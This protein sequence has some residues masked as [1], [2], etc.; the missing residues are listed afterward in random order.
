MAAHW[1]SRPWADQDPDSANHNKPVPGANDGASGVAVLLEIARVLKQN[2]PPVGV[3]IVLFDGED[4]GSEGYPDTYAAG[5]QY[6]AQKKSVHYAP[7]LGILLDMIG[8]REL[9][10]YREA[11]SVRYAPA[12][13]DLVWN[14]AARL[15]IS[16]FYNPVRHEVFDDHVPLLNVGIP[17]IDLIDFDYPYWHTVHDTPDKCSPESLEKVGRVVL[18]VIYNPPAS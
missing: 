1:D 15:G 11:N 7:Y 2:P 14:Y 13:V 10:I 8:D 9:Q 5:A 18:A 6:F 16:N 12:V 3:D 17:C 4:L